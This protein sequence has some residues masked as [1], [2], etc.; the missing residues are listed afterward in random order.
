MLRAVPLMFAVIGMT[1][2]AAAGCFDY[3]PMGFFGC[4]QRLGLGPG[5]PGLFPPAYV[6][7]L[8]TGYNWMPEPRFVVVPSAPVQ[9]YITTGQRAPQSEAPAK[10]ADIRQPMSFADQV[11]RARR[12]YPHGIPAVSSVWSAGQSA[13]PPEHK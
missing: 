7:P 1:T 12:L 11:E 6:C 3:W 2:P 13:P 4:G 5:Y 8:C 10:S 9:V